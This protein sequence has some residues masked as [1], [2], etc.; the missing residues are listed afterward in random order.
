VPVAVYR[1]RQRSV[2]D[3]QQSEAT[4]EWRHGDAAFA[5]FLVMFS[6]SRQF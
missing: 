3:E 1:N 6:L 4:G 2:P 5:D